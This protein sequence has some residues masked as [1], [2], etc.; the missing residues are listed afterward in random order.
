MNGQERLRHIPKTQSPPLKLTYFFYIKLFLE[1]GENSEVK[2]LA[3]LL[4]DPSLGSNT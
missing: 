4:E 1:A 3:A 2:W